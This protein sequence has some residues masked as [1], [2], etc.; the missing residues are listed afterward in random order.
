MKT[1]DSSF[2]VLETNEGTCGHC[3]QWGAIAVAIV[4]VGWAPGELVEGC[5]KC[6]KENAQ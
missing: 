4:Y 3:D 6:V 2:E 1:F 5:L